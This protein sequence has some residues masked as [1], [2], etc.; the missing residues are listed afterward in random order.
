MSTRKWPN[1][2]WYWS[3]WRHQKTFS[4]L[5]AIC[6][7]NSPVTVEL[8]AQGPATRSFDVFFDLR[9]NK[10]LSKQWWGSWFETPWRPLWRH[11]NVIA[12]LGTIMTKVQWQLNITFGWAVSFIN[13]S[14]RPHQSSGGFDIN[15]RITWNSSKFNWTRLTP[16]VE[17]CELQRHWKNIYR[18][19]D[20]ICTKQRKINTRDKDCPKDTYST[21]C[22]QLCKFLVLQKNG[23]NE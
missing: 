21:S 12:S 8:P 13:S 23:E 20:Y 3:W 5:L 10:R 4:A 18:E 22:Q 6:V 2:V 17:V 1:I 7:G 11:C 14:I 9:L 15:D 16:T 19:R